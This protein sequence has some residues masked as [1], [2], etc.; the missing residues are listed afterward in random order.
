MNLKAHREKPDSTKHILHYSIC[1]KS[2][3]E[4]RLY[5]ACQSAP[6][7]GGQEMHGGL[8][9]ISWVED[10]VLYSA[11]AVDYIGGCMYANHTRR[12]SRG[13][14]ML[15][16]PGQAAPVFT[17]FFPSQETTYKECH[18]NNKHYL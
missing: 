14:Q 2:K 5:L 12:G 16:L 1:R 10:K 18:S 4:E 7:Q 8:E 9:G 11:K 3:K 15:L 17:L 6:S 13:V